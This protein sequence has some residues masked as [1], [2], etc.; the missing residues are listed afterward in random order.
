MTKNCE[1]TGPITN[2]S[3]IILINKY[4]IFTDHMVDQVLF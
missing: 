1:Q 3:N 2:L 4:K